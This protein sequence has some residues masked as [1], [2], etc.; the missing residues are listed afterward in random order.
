MERN[1][2]E[3]EPTLGNILWLKA[4]IVR[5]TVVAFFLRIKLAVLKAVLQ[6]MQNGW[7]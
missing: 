5:M 3:M 2:M 7:I 4:G 1:L 6:L